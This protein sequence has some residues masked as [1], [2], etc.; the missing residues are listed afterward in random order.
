MPRVHTMSL[1]PSDA[2]PPLGL[3]GRSLRRLTLAGQPGQGGASR[4]SLTATHRRG[5]QRPGSVTVPRTEIPDFVT[6]A[7]LVVSHGNFGLLPES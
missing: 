5:S 3:R 7:C 1:Y 6:L 4:P 2:P